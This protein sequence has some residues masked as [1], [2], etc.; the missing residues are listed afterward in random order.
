MPWVCW[1][2]CGYAA[3]PILRRFLNPD[4]CSHTVSAGQHAGLITPN[5]THPQALE[6]AAAAAAELRASTAASAPPPSAPAPWLQ[7]SYLAAD[8]QDEAQLLE[9]LEGKLRALQAVR[10]AAAST[11]RSCGSPPDAARDADGAALGSTAPL[12]GA[13]LA[14]DASSLAAL[15]LAALRGRAR[16][17]QR[18]GSEADA[19]AQAAAAALA[20][21]EQAM[22]ESA[23]QLRGRLSQAAGPWRQTPGPSPSPQLLRPGAALPLMGGPLLFHGARAAELRAA[24]AAAVDA[25]GQLAARCGEVQVQLQDA[26]AAAAAAAATAAE[27]RE[28]ARAA[29]EEADARRRELQQVRLG[30]EDGRGPLVLHARGRAQLDPLCFHKCPVALLAWARRRCAADA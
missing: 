26:R 25:I 10:G 2:R 23:A 7:P 3:Y 18:R 19:A 5:A 9:Q 15:A 24:A 4:F 21:A 14:S 11:G 28:E 13:S 6:A 17:L 22:D 12:P 8:E 29:K 30:G 16:R 27:A 20:A 1:S